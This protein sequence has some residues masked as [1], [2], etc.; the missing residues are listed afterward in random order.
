ND[1]LLC[2]FCSPPLSSV[3]P[4]PRRI[5]YL[6]AESLD[7]L[8]GGRRIACETRL[9]EP[10][11]VV[12]RQSTD[13]LGID[14][15]DVVAA[16][17][18]IRDRA[19][20]GLTVDGV[21]AYLRVSRSFLERRFRRCVGHSPQQEIRLTQLRRIEELLRDTDLTLSEI[22]QLAGFAHTEY[23][24]VVYKRMTGRPPS[25]ARERLRR[26]RPPG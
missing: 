9:V 5:G 7:A 6:A 2:N 12:V 15:P 20:L 18:L 8:M 26:G 13:A 21:V 23:M 10:L 25:E 11:G 3:E 22:A 14:D 17:A 19:C 16:I 24:S 4:D 1:E